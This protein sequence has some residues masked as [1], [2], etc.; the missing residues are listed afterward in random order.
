MQDPYAF[1]Q[2]PQPSHLTGAQYGGVRR[3]RGAPSA[4]PSTFDHSG[5][6]APVLQTIPQPSFPI[7]PQVIPTPQPAFEPEEVHTVKPLRRRVGLRLPANYKKEIAKS[8]VSRKRRSKWVT[9]TDKEIEMKTRANTHVNAQMPY[10][11]MPSMPAPSYDFYGSNGGYMPDNYDY[12]ETEPLYP[13]QDMS[14]AAAMSSH[15][16]HMGHTVEDDD[17]E[18]SEE[19]GDGI[20]PKVS[21]QQ[22]MKI[23]LALLMIP[24]LIVILSSQKKFSS[25]NSNSN[26]DL[27]ALKAGGFG[28]LGGGGGGGAGAAGA[29]GQMGMGGSGVGRH[30]LDELGMGAQYPPHKRSRRKKNRYGRHRYT[31]ELEDH[32]RK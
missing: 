21:A 18:D 20:F 7:R 26:V 4:F 9:A 3:R 22:K 28:G 27:A 16:S 1:Y 25:S 23:G 29:L 15:M 14:G 5:Y 24:S 11:Q 2:Q 13:Y 32:Y 8:C 30:G 6:N 19:D 17:D 10:T 31:D 12:S